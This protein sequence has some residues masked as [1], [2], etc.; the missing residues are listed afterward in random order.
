VTVAASRRPGRRPRTLLGK[1]VAIIAVLIAVTS[2]V[3]GGVTVVA[4]H[5]YLIS[6]VDSQ[7]TVA[8]QRSLAEKGDMPPPG[9]HAGRPGMQPGSGSGTGQGSSTGHAS[10]PT[11]APQAT[12][13]EPV[14][15]GGP[16]QSPDTVVAVIVGDRFVVNGFVDPDGARHRLSTAA[17]DVLRS[18]PTSARPQTRDLP[19]LG[20]YRLVATS[21]PGHSTVITGL[22]LAPVDAA[23]DRLVLVVTIVSGSGLL[24]AALVAALTVRRTLRPLRRVAGTASSVTALDLDHA[25]VPATMRVRE[26]DIGS[27][28]EVGQVGSA[29]NRLLGH[30]SAALRARR[31]AE[32][33]MR[34]FVADASHELRT[35]L[36]TVRAYA[37]L[38]R[39]EYPDM[40]DGL[41]RN[42]QRIE[43]ESV[44]M[45]A[46]VEQLL[47]LAR[48]DSEAPVA[49]EPVD[50]SRLLAETV[51]DA[52]ASA[53]GH[54]WQLDL[55]AIPL[56][57][58]GDASQLRRMIVNLL[59]NASVHT[60]VGT[61]VEVIGRLG[62]DGFATVEVV[63]DGPGIPEDLLPRLFQRFVRGDQSRSRES[64]STGL[65]LA[66][67]DAVAA[68]HGGTATVESSAGRTVFRVSL[69]APG[70]L[71]RP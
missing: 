48:L 2:L 56:S 53:A 54:V 49:R 47:L 46:L 10:G 36:S 21:S 33:R 17:Q 3:I 7:L 60:P 58:P 51:A 61:T 30:M 22:P 15:I 16:G 50:V 35:P 8:S 37:E 55:P 62:T 1:L 64:G 40:P 9:Q 71:S 65:G 24:V 28:S 27:A 68:V 32:N 20:S 14:F 12:P 5:G 57:V 11:P 23:T 26:E 63:D 34:D 6:Q 66:I 43:S 69:P 19:G 39:L 38:S 67:V 25:D 18:L 44:R 41:C 29:L 45:S 4:L 70:S 31:S 13:N 59:T 52:Q 42:I